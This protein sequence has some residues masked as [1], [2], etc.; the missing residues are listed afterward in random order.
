MV[1]KNPD[2]KTDQ[3]YKILLGKHHLHDDHHIFK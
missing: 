2:R 1:I 3:G